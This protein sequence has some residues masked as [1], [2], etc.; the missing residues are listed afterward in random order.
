MKR[1]RFKKGFFIIS[2]LFITYIL[3]T[4]ISIIDYSTVDEQQ[5]ADVI[6]VLGAATSNGEV[7]PVYRERINHGIDLYNNGLADFIIMT[8]GTGKGNTISD[9]LA[10]KNYALSRGVPEKA[11]FL[12]ESSTITQ[13]NLFFSK[14]IMTEMGFVSAIIVSDPLHMKRAMLMAEDYDIN[15][16]SSPTPTTR[17]ISLKTKIPFLIREEFFYV[18]YR[19]YRIFN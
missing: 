1:K 6:I 11:I 8:G 2:L 13:E 17:Y 14:E 4:T 9:A 19:L 16:H 10:A 15:S 12:E 18:G 7:S 5:P 3:V